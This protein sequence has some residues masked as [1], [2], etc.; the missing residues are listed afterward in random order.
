MKRLIALSA[1]VVLL[2]SNSFAEELKVGDAAPTFKAKTESG[3]DFDLASRKGSW[4]VLYFYPK[5]GTPGCTKQACAY[6]DNLKKITDQGAGVFGISSD[7]VADQKK[8]HTEHHLNFSLLADPK[9]DVIN[10]YGT[11]MPLVPM[12]KRWTFVID[13]DLKI[14]SIQKGV[15]PVVDSEKT[16][17]LITTLKTAKN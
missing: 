5:A 2:A 16:A 8:F 4:T 9:E 15:D 11:K 1:L 17:A 7:T 14:R 12:S 6:R 10:A 3:S 13:P